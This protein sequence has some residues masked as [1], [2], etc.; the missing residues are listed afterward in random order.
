[1]S[2]FPFILH[3]LYTANIALLLTGILLV[4]DVWRPIGDALSGITGL[5]MP[6]MH[7]I[8]ILTLVF[9]FIGLFL[10]AGNIRHI[11]AGSPVAVNKLV[12]GGLI[13]VLVLAN[14][15]IIPIVARVGIMGY[16][17][18][19]TRVC[20]VFLRPKTDYVLPELLRCSDGTAVVDRTMWMERRRPELLALFEREV[21]GRV[22]DKE[23]VPEV[24]AGR[25]DG[26]ALAGEAIRKEVTLGFE[27]NGE[28]LNLNVLMYVPAKG[29][30]PAPA[31][32]GLNFYG[33][34]TI[35]TDPGITLS[36]EWIDTDRAF[37]ELA[38]RA[39]AERRGSRATHWPVERILRRGYALVTAYYYDIDPDF[40]DGFQ[41]GIHP[42]FYYRPGQRRPAPDEWG[43]I[44]AW[45]WGLSRI[46]DYLETDADIDHTRVAVMGHSRLGK[47]ALWAGAQDERFAI[48]ISNDSGC[49]GAA[50][51]RRR[52]GETVADITSMFPHWFCDNFRK[53]AG[54]EA[55]LPVDQHMLIALIAPRPVYVASAELD[56]W[57]DPEGEF[58][59]AMAASDVYRLFGNEE[60]AAD[61]PPALHEP[62]MG[63]IGYHVRAGV[64]DVTDYDWQRFMD[65]ADLHLGSG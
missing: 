63:A 11:A 34:H 62:V 54:R 9:L 21:Y 4:R 44:A 39:I 40:D 6:W 31:F 55:E 48:V 7:V 28:R 12:T 46:M 18:V 13:A 47:T 33:N 38:D 24:S 61:R 56:L 10:V 5:G 30:E 27:S 1:M 35:H 16:V 3:I 25:I 23:I 43:S 19:V 53:Y 50:L 14:A 58:L 2:R 20:T 52:Y 65:F 26:N 22:P 64:H 29:A 17:P 32:V 36:R 15:S 57:A 42:L 8:F 60:L 45:S 59:S 37:S 49:M 41:N 51:S